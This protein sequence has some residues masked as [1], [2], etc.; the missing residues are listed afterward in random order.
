MVAGETGLSP[1]KRLENSQPLRTD[2]FAI[3][4]GM[5]VKLG[6]FT[7][8]KVLFPAATIYITCSISCRFLE[9]LKQNRNTEKRPLYMSVA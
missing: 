3:L 8:F 2:I 4:K 9:V 5:T 7:N 1:Y 6:H